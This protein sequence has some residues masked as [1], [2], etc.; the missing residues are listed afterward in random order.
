M[1]IKYANH[2]DM[3]FTIE[4]FHSRVKTEIESW[5]DGMLADFARICGVMDGV[6]A[7]ICGCH[8]H[9]LWEVA[10]SS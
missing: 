5:P 10:F 1:V 3:K 9:A 7:K 2:I 8:T 6:R 4:Y